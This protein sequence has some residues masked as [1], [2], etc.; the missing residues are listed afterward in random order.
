MCKAIFYFFV[1]INWPSISAAQTIIKD[2][3]FS[4]IYY[5]VIDHFPETVMGGQYMIPHRNVDGKPFYN[6]NDFENGTLVISGFK[7]Q[8]IPLQYDLWDDILITITP[9]HRQKIILNPFKIDQF[10]LSDGAVFVRRENVSSYHQQKNGF[11]RQ[12]IK[13]EIGLYCKHWIE[14]KRRSS[15]FEMLSS[16]IREHR[17]FLEIANQLF[18]VNKRKDDYELLELQKKEVR[19]KAKTEGIKYK[20]NQ[21]R[22]LEIM[23]EMANQQNNE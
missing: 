5:E 12:I 22:Y 2:I 16:Y 4:P 1:L 8:E 17:Y 3:S 18:S 13:D 15:T 9:V 20:K 11:Y 6:N 14:L 21:E 23:V 7:F 19:L 10:I